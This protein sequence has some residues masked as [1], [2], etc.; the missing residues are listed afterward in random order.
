MKG[1]IVKDLLFIK[2]N[3]KTFLIILLAFSIIAISNENYNFMLYI[4]PFFLVMM[5]ISTFNYDEFNNWNSYCL[6]L[7]ISRKKIVQSKY[8][9]TIFLAIVGIILTAIIIITFKSINQSLN[10]EEQISNFCGSFFA[11]SLIISILYPL[12]Y[13]FGSEKG[14][15]FIFVIVLIVSIIIGI[16]FSLLEQLSINYHSLL[17]SLN[18]LNYIQIS[19]FMLV[20][21]II[22]IIISYLISLRIYQKKEF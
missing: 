3:M 17:S 5:T 12:I 14:R 1:L 15:I 10:L 11:V 16:I 6:T 7:P 4:I 8:L 20:I 13:K 9:F 2:N 22:T 18:S 21:S 19:L